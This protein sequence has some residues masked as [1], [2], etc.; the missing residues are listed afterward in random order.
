MFFKEKKRQVYLD[1]AAATQ[2][3]TQVFEKMLP[4]IKEG[5]YNPGAIYTEA[6]DLRSD[7]Q[8]FRAKIA[9]TISARE[10]EIIFCDGGSEA[11]NLALRGFVDFFWKNQNEKPLIFISAI[12]HASVLETA[13]ALQ[14][15][16]KIDL[17]YIPVDE[18]GFVQE[19]EL[20]KMLRE[21]LPHFISVMYVNGE[22]GV[23]QNIK[24]IAKHI[25]HHKKHQERK[26]P[27]F[28]TDAV[29]AVN[30]LPLHVARL[31]VDMMSCNASKIY[32][33]K[34][35]AFLYKKTGIKIQP[36]VFGGDQEY[37]L[38]AGTE[39]LAALAG[40]SE[41]FVLAQG[42][43]ESEV[44]KL[45]KL[46]DFFEEK[47]L[48]KFSG[49]IIINSVEVERIPNII[50]ISFPKISSEELVIRLAAKGI[51]VSVKSACKSDTEG[52]SHVILAMRNNQ[53][54]SIRFSMGRSTTK[55][56]IE[57]TLKNLEQIVSKMKEVYSEYYEK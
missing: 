24:K 8:N 18:Q 49:E 23:V 52:D 25:R 34:K 27:L 35:A 44:K 40:M 29:Q 48:E 43:L 36:L 21:E 57:Y 37:S 32:G 16:N 33:P 46:R 12:E 9:K 15:Q 10:S 28:H 31:G 56:D 19:K 30:Y 20:R 13:K 17:K 14:E 4:Y 1:H 3:D 55:K 53:T 5:F 11:N 6:F 26:Y 42:Q 7:I 39:N 38:R 47:L 45:T 2:I 22:T 51:L 50:N 54:Q 41:S